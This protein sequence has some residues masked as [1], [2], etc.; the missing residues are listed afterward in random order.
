[1]KSKNYLP[2]LTASLSQKKNDH[3]NLLSIIY[4]LKRHV[5]RIMIITEH[6]SM[7]YV[8]TKFNQNKTFIIIK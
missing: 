6:R 4:N 1:M 2:F 5:I 3:V 8:G 7:K